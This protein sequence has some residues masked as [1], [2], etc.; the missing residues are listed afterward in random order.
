MVR[1]LDM[2]PPATT[3]SLGEFESA[4]EAWKAINFCLLRQGERVDSVTDDSSVGSL[5]GRRQRP[6]R[7][8]T[9][10]SFRISNIRKRLIVSEARKLNFAFLFAN[11]LWTIS[12]S[13]RIDMITHYNKR[14]ACFSDDGVTLASAFGARLFS[15]SAHQFDKVADLLRRDP[16]T[17]RAAIGLFNDE[18]LAS[19]SKDVSCALALQFLIRDGLLNCIVFMRSQSA[20]MV[21]PYD[22]FLF[23]MLHEA[24]AARIGRKVGWYQHEC[25]SLHFY[26]DEVGMVNNIY[27]ERG[28]GQSLEMPSMTSFSEHDRVEL[29]ETERQVREHIPMTSY[30][31]LSSIKTILSSTS[32]DQYWRL[33]FSSFM[34]GNLEGFGARPLDRAFPRRGSRH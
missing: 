22:L 18:A 28:S 23:T 12:G 29:I 6:F 30:A 1:L 5:F 10:V 14:G 24:M 19:H 17:R 9:G 13:N 25:A 8:L 27:G 2:T 3:S 11:Y 31:G 7:E 21:M 33:V 15:S 20:A 26:E 32:L 4:Q 34:S 16:Y